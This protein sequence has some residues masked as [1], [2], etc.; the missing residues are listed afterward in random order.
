MIFIPF[1][2][3]G[4]H[5]SGSFKDNGMSTAMT[6]GKMLGVKGIVCASTGNTS[7]TVGCMHPNENMACDVS[8][9]RAKLPL[10]DTGQAFQFGAQ[11]IQV[12]GTSTML[13]PPHLKMRRKL[14]DILSTQSTLSALRDRRLSCIGSSIISIGPN[15]LDSVSRRGL[16]Y[17]S[18]CGKCL[19][20]LYRMGMD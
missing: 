2:T 11:V 10:A 16:G 9:R 13:S 18:S 7:A 4:P 8:S 3:E 5:P 20:E 12:Q 15:R 17:T 1:N 14:V 19:I 6:H